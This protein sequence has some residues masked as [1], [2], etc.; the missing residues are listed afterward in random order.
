MPKRVGSRSRNS[1]PQ[2]DLPATK[3]W[4]QKPLCPSELRKIRK[5]G[6]LCPAGQAYHGNPYTL[7]ETGLALRPISGAMRNRQLGHNCSSATVS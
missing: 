1:L 2:C 3:S 4:P 6:V 7:C 5:L